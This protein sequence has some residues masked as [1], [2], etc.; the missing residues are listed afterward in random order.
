MLHNG[1]FICRLILIELLSTINIYICHKPKIQNI[2]TS[3]SP[4]K[5]FLI[6]S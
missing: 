1:E 5:L 2:P 3:L 6:K 4:N